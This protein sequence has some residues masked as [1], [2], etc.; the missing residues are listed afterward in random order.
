MNSN[1]IT[2]EN[3]PKAV[4]QLFNKVANIERLLSKNNS[5]PPPPDRPLTITECAEFLSLTVPTI[6]SKISRREIPFIKQGK[7]VYFS[8]DILT[9]WL[10]D[11]CK[12]TNKEISNEAQ[13]AQIKK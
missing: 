5:A 11:G 4:S 13:E 2:L 1:E 7:R 3:L 10:M 9:K 8:R 12:K 6:Y